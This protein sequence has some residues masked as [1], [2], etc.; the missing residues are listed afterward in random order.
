MMSELRITSYTARRLNYLWLPSPP[1][2]N[3]RD[4][5]RFFGIAFTSSRAPSTSEVDIKASVKAR[6]PKPLSGRL[7]VE[8]CLFAKIST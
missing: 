8:T 3:L 6:A 1:L 7:P 2:E 4:G 5:T